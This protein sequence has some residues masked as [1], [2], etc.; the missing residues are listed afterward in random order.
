M[1]AA[2]RRARRGPLASP[3]GRRARAGKWK[4]TGSDMGQIWGLLFGRWRLL[5]ASEGARWAAKR[6]RVTG[7]SAALRQPAGRAKEPAI[8]LGLR[9]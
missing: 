4:P 3:G 9:R 5:G 7:A 2:G 6:L 1:P 8:G